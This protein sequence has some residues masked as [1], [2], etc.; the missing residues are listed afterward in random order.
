[1]NT[2]SH[3]N[4][5]NSCAMRMA[6]LALCVG[7]LC[8]PAMETARAASTPPN[9]MTYQGHLVDNLG[10]PLG[11]S[12]PQNF[13]VMFRIFEESEG[14]ARLWSE[15]QVVTVDNGDFSV[16]LGEGTAITGETNPA[17]G[18]AAIFAGVTADARYLELTVTISGSPVVIQ[19]RLRLLPA[20]YAFLATHATRLV[21][22]STGVPFVSLVGT[23]VNVDGG[24]SVAGTLNTTGAINA[25]AGL[26]GLTSAQVPSTLDG[27]RT[28]NGPV[29]ITGNNVLEFGANISPKESNNGKIG[30][31]AFSSGASVAL[32]IV[33]AGTTLNSRRITFHSQGGAQF[34][35]NVGIGTAAPASPLDITGTI[36]RSLTV[37]GSEGTDAVVAGNLGG[38]ASIGA[39][40]GALNA[41]ADL[42]LNPDGG[43]VGIG[44]RNPPYLLSLATADANQTRIRIDSGANYVEFGR[45]TTYAFIQLN[46]SHWTTANRA[47]TYDGDANWDFSSDRKLKKDIVDAEPMLDRAMQVKVRRYR[48]KEDPDN[49]AHK[50]GVVAQEVQPLFPHLVSEIQLPTQPGSDA[51]GEKV[52]QVGYGDFALIALKAVQ[53]LKTK[54]DAELSEMREQLAAVIR[55]NQELR[56]RLASPSLTK[57]SQ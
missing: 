1:M 33:G 51:P 8:R 28:F 34:L 10:T 38:R 20:P 57:T 22:S 37:R 46:N 26:I 17:G 39:H 21:N 55:D 43:R 41:W 24:L 25:A 50:L 52:L 4:L 13:P 36:W 40:N 14:G 44:T 47:V 18:L 15:E 3:M 32:D 56:S 27:T 23:T 45:T 11:T 5:M 7:A 29:R 30:Y 19:P 2:R 16:I 48:W 54:Y 9:R 31:G 42:S 6:V 35:G 49:A 53:E 12:Q